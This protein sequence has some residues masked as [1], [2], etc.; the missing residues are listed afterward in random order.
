MDGRGSLTDC[1]SADN[2]TGSASLPRISVITPVRN[3]NPYLLD[4]L[5]SVQKQDYPFVEHIVIDDGSD[6]GGW[7]L[8]TLQASAGIRW[9]GHP[10]CGQYPTQNEGLR[11][12]TG[13]LVT[14]ICADDMYAGSGALSA[15]AR[16]WHPGVKVLYGDSLEL[17]AGGAPLPYQVTGHGPLF[18][19]DLLTWCVVRHSSV[20]IDRQF[21]MNRRL[22]FDE[23]FHLCGDWEWLIRVFAAARDDILYVPGRL[24][25]YRNHALQTSQQSWYAKSVD[26]E[27]MRVF[28]MYGGSVTAYRY[29]MRSTVWPRR[30]QKARGLMR[31]GDLRAVCR[32]L[33]AAVKRCLAVRTSA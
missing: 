6:D 9:W 1:R 7:T 18:S 25:A 13:D 12:A 10:N 8:Q 2:E 32:W 11:A 31:A 30:W 4:L 16:A 26:T 17:D 21:V 5:E 29:A 14:I 19:S 15:V 28:A 23:S 22:W 20:F 27:R 33:L 3:G 24:G